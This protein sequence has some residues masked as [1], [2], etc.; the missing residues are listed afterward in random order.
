[1]W[2]K[3]APELFSGFAKH[4]NLSHFILAGIH[5]EKKCLRNKNLMVKITPFPWNLKTFFS[6]VKISTS[7][8]LFF[9]CFF[10]FCYPSCRADNAA[11]NL[12]CCITDVE[13]HSFRLS[14]GFEDLLLSYSPVSHCSVQLNHFEITLT[15]CSWENLYYSLEEV[16]Y[17][18]FG[19]HFTITWGKVR[20]YMFLR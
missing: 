1:M 16:G 18:L 10:F 11:R 20:G 7:Q 8:N 5:A 6:H 14:Y 13:I 19:L 12:F 17:Y 2:H 4:I 3:P 9:S 15:Q